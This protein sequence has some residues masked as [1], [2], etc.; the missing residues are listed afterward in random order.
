MVKKGEGKHEIIR[1]GTKD[2]EL[3]NFIKTNLQLGNRH[4]EG[5]VIHRL[6]EIYIGK[7]I[8]DHNFL[9]VGH[10]VKMISGVNESLDTYINLYNEQVIITKNWKR[11][12]ENACKV[13]NLNMTE[14]IQN[15]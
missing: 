5:D 8:G 13:G 12:F 4:N 11:R 3:L 7:K 15:F 1:I 14:L 2:R 9:Q 6:I 10:D